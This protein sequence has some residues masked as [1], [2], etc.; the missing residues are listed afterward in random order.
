[1]VHKSHQF[2]L[3]AIIIA[4]LILTQCGPV[5]PV[6]TAVKTDEQPPSVQVQKDQVGPYIAGQNP[7]AGQRLELSPALEFTFDRE[8]DQTKT[9][10]AFALR[11]S[12]NKPVPGK[13]AWLDPKT[14]SFRPDSTL[15]PATVYKATFSTSAVDL[16]GQA[17]RDEIRLD[18]TTID[19]LAVG[20]VFPVDGTEEIDP[21][22]NITVIFNH[23]V[24]PLQI[25]E[26]QKDLPQPLTFS[27][28]VAGQGVWVNSSV[29]VF[30]PEKGLLS[31]T[32]YKVK[33]DAGLKDTNGDALD[34]S[35]AWNF[36]TRAPL[37]GNFSLKN[38]QENP[39]E[40][41]GSVLLDQAF[42]VT[43]LQPMDE[44]S[45]SEAVTLV[46]RETVQSFPTKLTWDKEFTTLTI[47][48]V[49]RYKI[50]S[51]YD[52]NISEKA[53]AQDGGNLKKGLTLKFGTLP[54][55]RI[56]DVFPKPNSNG[57]A[58]GGKGFNSDISVTFAS[59]MKLDSLKSKIVITPQPKKGLQWYFNDSN[60]QLNVFGLEPATEY[61][62][63]LLPG[64]ADIYG[65]TIQSEQSY[66]F[67][68]GDLFPY[69]R[70]VLPWTPLIYRAQGPQEVYFEHINLDS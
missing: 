13:V 49:G 3:G 1:M 23:P 55:P 57:A 2:W 67:K 35:F 14:F 38:G 54:L 50:A 66:T 17:L 7:P 8:M 6:P 39:P 32:N 22:T 58:P 29:Y 64:M 40:N 48:P 68:T 11:D 20:Q 27:P 15:E 18:L 41:I 69:A 46:N 63:R 5:T 10:E 65:N 60:W 51:F 24:V 19:A 62:V 26:E 70:L 36:S 28:E 37:I 42:I 12:D 16:D 9:A 56:V 34:Q 31:G 43:F 33:V 4:A 25:K 21:S 47:E 30:Q 53:Q 61:V 45:V 59:P 44:K 52:L